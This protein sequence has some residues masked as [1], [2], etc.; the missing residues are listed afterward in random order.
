MTASCS[1]PA[2]AAVV[3]ADDMNMS[4]KTYEMVALDLDGTLLASNHRLDDEQA[5]YLR[6]LREEKNFLV[7]FATGR[8]ASS[9]Y[10]HVRKLNIPE[11]PVVCS[12]GA[13]GLIC[14]ADGS[15]KEE[16][17][18]DP[19]PEEVV[20][21]TV[22]L[23]HKLGY[24]VQYYYED[25]T[26][27]N[28]TTDRHY[29]LTT[30]YSNLTGSII[31]HVEDDFEPLLRAQKLPSKLLVLFDESHHQEAQVEFKKEFG[32][33][34]SIVCGLFD[35]FV[36]VLSPKVNKGE[37]LKKMVNEKESS[38]YI[39]ILKTRVDMTLNLPQKSRRNTFTYF[40]PQ[41]LLIIFTIFS[42]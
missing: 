8:G 9:V 7:T 10:E 35:W 15:I 28:Q 29:E 17:F 33:D 30:L 6:S 37:G 41:P 14:R 31:T 18:Y 1:D 23:S 24:A 25:D 12:N 4:T 11:L 19:V 32:S 39:R 27:A 38:I 26:Y 13:R 2:E 20:R 36:E 40:S 16:L 3:S 22:A 21:R 42:R 5:K 34:A